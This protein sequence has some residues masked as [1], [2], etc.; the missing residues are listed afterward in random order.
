MSRDGRFP[1]QKVDPGR[2]ALPWQLIA[3]LYRAAWLTAESW[4]IMSVRAYLAALMAHHGKTGIAAE[5]DRLSQRAA[6]TGKAGLVFVPEA[7]SYERYCTFVG[8]CHTTEESGRN[9]SNEPAV[10]GQWVKKV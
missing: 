2:M 10:T 6:M 9:D 7:S 8:A 5:T 4:K 1:K 3:V